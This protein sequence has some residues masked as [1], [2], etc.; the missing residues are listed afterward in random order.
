MQR[1]YTELQLGQV[2]AW[3]SSRAAKSLSCITPGILAN[4]I[5]GLSIPQAGAIL[6]AISLL[7][8]QIEGRSRGI[9]VRD[10]ASAFEHNL[11]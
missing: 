9:Y 5:E 7:C 11:G 1:I 3:L 10:P 8:R 6:R 4:R 2:S